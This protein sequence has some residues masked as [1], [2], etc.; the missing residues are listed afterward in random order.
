[1]LDCLLFVAEH[2]GLEVF[3]DDT[4]TAVVLGQAVRKDL[5]DKLWRKLLK[6]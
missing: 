4:G 1:M 6:V 5:L 2:I 3:E